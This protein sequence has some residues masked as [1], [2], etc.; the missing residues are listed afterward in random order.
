MVSIATLGLYH[1]L[2]PQRE[3]TVTIEHVAPSS[4]RR[5]VLTVN[6]KG[7]M[8]MEGVYEDIPGVHYYAF[9]L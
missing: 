9:G 2:A 3:R 1:W 8:I 6:D 7:D 5:T 4:A